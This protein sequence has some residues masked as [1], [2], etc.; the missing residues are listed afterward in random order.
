MP[1]VCTVCSVLDHGNIGATL[2]STYHALQMQ[3]R[4]TVYLASSGPRPRV[5]HEHPTERVSP[6]ASAGERRTRQYSGSHRQH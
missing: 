3:D 4:Y 2:I 6:L 1:C 5:P